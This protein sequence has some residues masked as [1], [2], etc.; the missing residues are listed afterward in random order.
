MIHIRSAQPGLSLIEIMITIMLIALFAALVGP[1]VF[2]MFGQGQK[3][4]TKIAL[5]NI[6]EGI[7][8]FHADTGSYPTTLQELYIRPA[9]EKLAKRWEG[10]YLKKDPI[11]PWGSDFVYQLNAKG[12][13]PPYVLYSWG[14]NH[15]GS[16]QE[17]W[18]YP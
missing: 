15:E 18:I 6:E 12:A 7:E 4:A 8:L 10:P 13:Q 3:R 9:D 2:E 14:P 1:R 16:P 11:D 17:E 5:K